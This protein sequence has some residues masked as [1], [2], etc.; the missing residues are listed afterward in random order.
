MCH[1]RGGQPSVVICATDQIPLFNSRMARNLSSTDRDGIPQTSQRPAESLSR[2]LSSASS[3]SQPSAI[4]VAFRNLLKTHKFADRRGKRGVSMILCPQQGAPKR[5]VQK[6]A[7]VQAFLLVFH[8]RT[9]RVRV[10][11]IFNVLRTQSCRRIL[12]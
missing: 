8:E 5:D 11:H 9:F 10:V 1:Q 2:P 4:F 6:R 3:Q 7:T 12:L